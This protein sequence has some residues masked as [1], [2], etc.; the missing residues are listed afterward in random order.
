M[1]KSFF[2]LEEKELFKLR[3]EEQVNKEMVF[4]MRIMLKRELKIIQEQIEYAKN[5]T[6]QI[7]FKQ[8]QAF[9]KQLEN[10]KM[11]LLNNFSFLLENDNI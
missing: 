8:S 2:T 6:H 4:R 10:Y 9:I 5:E 1:G 3:S 7:F 11:D